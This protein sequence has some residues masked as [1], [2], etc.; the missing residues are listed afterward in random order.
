MMPKDKVS[1]AGVHLALDSSLVQGVHQPLVHGYQPVGAEHDIFTVDMVPQ[2]EEQFTAVI[3][4]GS[5][6]LSQEID[7][8]QVLVAEGD[9]Q[10]LDHLALEVIQ[11]I[12][13][14][15]IETDDVA[16]AFLEGSAHNDRQT[17][18]AKILVLDKL[19]AE[20]HELE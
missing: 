15:N 13:R 19:V 11:Q 2:P 20:Q 1:H 14:V 18:G 6:M 17:E 16:V 5:Q 9:D 4:F 10:V 8:V 3:A 12:D 7:I